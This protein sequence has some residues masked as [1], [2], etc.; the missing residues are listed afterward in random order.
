MLEKLQHRKNKLDKK[1]KSV[2]AWRKVTCVLFGS[3]FAALIICSVVA[4]L[5]AAPPIAAALA[6]TSSVPLGSM[7]KWFDSMWKEY[8]SVLMTEKDLLGAMQAGNF[9]VIAD[10]DSI[11]VLINQLEDHISSMLESAEFAFREEEA[12]RFGVDQ[13]GKKLVE[14]M[15]SIEDL[16]K[17]AD[18]CSRDIKWARTVV[19]Q[20]LLNTHDEEDAADCR[21]KTRITNRPLCR[22]LRRPGAPLSCSMGSKAARRSSPRVLRPNEILEVGYGLSFKPRV[23]LLLTFFRSDP[24]VKPVDEWQLKLSLLDFLRSSS[25]SRFPKMTSSCASGLTSTSASATGPWLP[26]RSGSVT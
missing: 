15:K 9:L 12:V 1:L 7:G 5:V 21:L 19:L 26:A 17:Q 2:R 22:L 18:Q 11:R 10:L 13:I 3:A 16:A 24:A 4:A 23:K 14:F 25:R 8:Q 20:K 6:A